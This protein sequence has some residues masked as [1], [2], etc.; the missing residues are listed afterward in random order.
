MPKRELRVG[1]VDDDSAMTSA[2]REWIR[3]EHPEAMVDCYATRRDAL[4]ALTTT[5]Y[6][7][8]VVDMELETSK[9]DGYSI[10]RANHQRHAEFERP[11]VMVVSAR[12]DVNDLRSAMENHAVWDYL[13]KPPLLERTGPIFRGTFLQRFG[14]VIEVARSRQSDLRFDGAFAWWKGNRLNLSV[15]EVQLLRALHARRLDE[16]PAMTWDQIFEMLNERKVGSW[17]NLQKGC[18]RQYITGIRHALA[19]QDRELRDAPP[20]VRPQ[21]DPIVTHMGLGYSWREK[22]R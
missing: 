3:A 12:Q 2:Y 13:D 22:N 10:I 20:D 17:T 15:A 7:V 8:L 9:D 16:D 21:L 4:Q 1:V 19:S 11:A 5:R 6:D 14:K 18:V